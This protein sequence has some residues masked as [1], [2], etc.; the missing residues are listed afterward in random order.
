MEWAFLGIHG[1]NGDCICRNWTQ[2][3]MLGV[4][5]F[6]V[7]ERYEKEKAHGWR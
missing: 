5:I 2:W 3:P 7:I 1:I 6:A 4:F